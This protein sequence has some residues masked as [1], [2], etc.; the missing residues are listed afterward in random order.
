MKSWG[1]SLPHVPLQVFHEQLFLPCW[2]EL[3]KGRL[4]VQWK[5]SGS[6]GCWTLCAAT[7]WS[8]AGDSLLCPSDSCGDRGPGVRPLC[9]WV[10]HME[11]IV[12]F[13]HSTVYVH[14]G[15]TK[16]NLFV[17]N[18]SLRLVGGKAGVSSQRQNC[19]AAWCRNL[20]MAII[21]MI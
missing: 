6:W 5:G 3:G 12:L 18:C 1:Q 19:L 8:W 2:Q 7:V 10:S 20:I 21:V 15:F 11:D 14:C 13:S 9:L 4:K 16:R 17:E